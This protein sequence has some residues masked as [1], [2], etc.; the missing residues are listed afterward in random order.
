M[1]E[2]VCLVCQVWLVLEGILH[3]GDALL[4]LAKGVVG[5]ALLVEDLRVAIVDLQGCGEVIYAVLVAFHIVVALSSILKVV[6]VLWLSLDSFVKAG[7]SLLKV[8]SRVKAASQSVMDCCTRFFFVV[9]LVFVF[10]LQDGLASFELFDG[11]SHLSGFDLGGRKVK[12][13]H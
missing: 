3:R 7:D 6:D 11:L 4:V 12:D 8:A 13:G 9:S 1:I 10:L 5:D 2:Y